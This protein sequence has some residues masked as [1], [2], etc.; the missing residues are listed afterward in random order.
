[1]DFTIPQ[2][3]VDD[4]LAT[5]GTGT[6][7]TGRTKPQTREQVG[8]YVEPW[9]DNLPAEEPYTAFPDPM[10]P[11]DVPVIPDANVYP[12]EPEDSGFDG[13]T[14]AFKAA[15]SLASPSIAARDWLT[16]ATFPEQYNEDL[17]L[18][19]DLIKDLPEQYHEDILEASSIQ[20]AQGMQQRALLEES[21]M[22]DLTGN[23]GATAV[24]ATLV[25]AIV[26]PLTLVGGVAEAKIAVGLLSKG[27][28]LQ[29]AV[30]MG[31][32]TSAQ[33]ATETAVLAGA[34]E[35]V[36][37]SDVFYAG[38]LGGA[39]GSVVGSIAGKADEVSG[40]MD[41]ADAERR[42]ISSNL[43]QQ[44]D[45]LL[46]DKAKGVPAVAPRV[47][48]DGDRSVFADLTDT[49]EL[50]LDGIMQLDG[51]KVGTLDA[52]GTRAVRSMALE[53][54][55][56][57]IAGELTAQDVLNGPTGTI[58]RNNPLQSD[59]VAVLKSKSKIAQLLGIELLED[60]A[61][62]GGRGK[63]AAMLKQKVERALLS[64]AMPTLR[65]NY[66]QFAKDN[67]VHWM[68]KSYWGDTKD[69]WN[70]SLRLE[71]EG[72]RTAALL[73]QAPEVSS[74]A[75][76]RG[77]ADAWQSMMDEAL[78]VGKM[79]GIRAF[80]HIDNVSGYVPLKW[81]GRLLR[82]AAKNGMLDDYVELAAEGYR[83]VGMPPKMANSISKHIINR[84]MY[85]DIG[86]DVN[87]GV[88]ISKD[89][90]NFLEEVM[91]EVAIPEEEM[92]AFFS[93]IDTQAADR[94]TASMARRRTSI[95]LTTSRNG[96][97]LI[98]IVDNDMATLGTRYSTEVSGRSALARKGI[99][100][101]A[102][103][104]S[105]REAV[106]SSVAGAQEDPAAMAKR[107]DAI[108]NQFLG[109]PVGTG[110]NRNARRLMDLA[111][112]SS[113]GMVQFAQL[114]ETGAIMA[115][116]G[117]ATMFKASPDLLK[118]RREMKA[119][120]KAGADTSKVQGVLSEL[121]VHFGGIWDEHLLYR[122]EVRLM[123]KYGEDGAV[124][125]VF[126]RVIASA[127]EMMGNIN[128]MNQIKTMQ[129][130]FVVMMQADKV[131]QYLK[132]GTEDARLL[133]RFKETG[134]DEKFLKKLR[135]R[136]D[137]GTITFQD[138]GAIDKLNMH[139]WNDAA[140]V[141]D[142]GVGLHR[143]SNQLIQ[144]PMIGE[145]SY[146]QHGTIGSMLTQF[147]TYPLVAIEKQ[148][149]RHARIND[150]ELYLTMT[151]GMGLS[152]MLSVAKAGVSNIGA[153]DGMKNFQDSMEPRNLAIS[154]MK[155]V[156][157]FGPAVEVLDGL[158]ALG[159]TSPVLSSN[160]VGRTGRVYQP[161]VGFS[162]RSIPS[163]GT[164]FDIGRGAAGVFK[165]VN[166][167][168]DHTFDQRDFR[169]V[170]GSAPWNNTVQGKV[171]TNLAMRAFPEKQQ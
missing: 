105:I 116:H 51:Y 43:I 73:N 154:S 132:A 60:G 95:D 110:V 163:V 168:Y 67:N 45:K 1:L 139:T 94:G 42:R 24:A 62:I 133:T 107:L 26:D 159:I 166:P 47:G 57:D 131:I 68:S 20:E 91:K 96:K 157:V 129:Q 15:Y 113:L 25:A 70:K 121:K 49:D 171:I 109:R 2:N 64:I 12:E 53:A 92:R 169:Y 144:L 32:L 165:A 119:A 17:Q 19:M 36:D 147:R 128:G 130:Q 75:A 148:M 101:D 40:I 100:D 80:E 162:D 138:N 58:L 136:I 59:A 152:A 120:V 14:T 134:W 76:V 11:A 126:D 63:S 79:S 114:A 158:S 137:N 84:S 39:V 83:N 111:T 6:A 23:G 22:R 160:T 90:R 3:L 123:D 69:A 28:R 102:S 16:Q 52:D 103:W 86:L 98:D 46:V 13:I 118:F 41:Y 170:I 108:Y 72:R 8:A 146:W 81:S 97:S 71:L 89:S 21:Q 44:E 33:A 155:W 65:T 18:R 31:A 149:L 87:P 115:S 106:L 66:R 167:M 56:R 77:A 135:K 27:S 30:K 151:Y 124:A 153:K 7:Y 48:L 9:V 127:S 104:R 93:K 85:K 141:E 29:K 4:F 10:K 5:K 161:T 35:S 156:N 164:A 143:H 37:G 82:Q 50:H 112:V 38:L 61:G 54:Y 122:P 142:F 117:I 74:S 150:R 145:T 125:Q 34:R 88:L 55:R 78:K 140:L 99:K